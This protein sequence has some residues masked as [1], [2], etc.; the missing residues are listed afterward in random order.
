MDYFFTN[1][2][3]LIWIIKLHLNR[4]IV[5]LIKVQIHINLITSFEI[6]HF[7]HRNNYQGIVFQM[8]Q[9]SLLVNKLVEQQQSI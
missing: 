1:G 2:T 6:I 7:I 4:K 3:G 9:Y 5:Y 8:A